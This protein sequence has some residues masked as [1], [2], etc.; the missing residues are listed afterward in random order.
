M[1]DY[2]LDK[3]RLLTHILYFKVIFTGFTLYS[4]AL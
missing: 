2:V 4:K 3:H 1:D